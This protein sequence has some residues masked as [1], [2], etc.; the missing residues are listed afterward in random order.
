MVFS[1]IRVGSVFRPIC[2]HLSKNRIVQ[3]SGVLISY[4]VSTDEQKER[5]QWILSSTGKR[6][7]LVPN[8]SCSNLSITILLST[9]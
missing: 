3:Q 9:F 5:V 1:G 2:G 6:L 8:V 7:T 4:F